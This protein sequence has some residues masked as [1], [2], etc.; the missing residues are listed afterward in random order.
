MERWLR[1]HR[2]GVASYLL[3]VLP[4]H[5]PLFE[6]TRQ[7]LLTYLR[8]QEGGTETRQSFLLS[9]PPSVLDLLANTT[10]QH[11]KVGSALFAFY[12]EV[13]EVLNQLGI[14]QNESPVGLGQ[15]WSYH[16][17]M[18]RSTPLRLVRLGRT[19]FRDRKW[20][21][22]EKE[23]SMVRQLVLP[24]QI[25]R[26]PWSR[27]KD[28]I[29]AV[30]EIAE[31]LQDTELWAQIEN[32]LLHHLFCWPLLVF[33]GSSGATANLGVSLPISV[34]LDLL[35]DD[36]SFEDASFDDTSFDRM[37]HRRY[38]TIN[39]QSGTISV[40]QWIDHLEQ[41]VR[42]GKKLWRAKHGNHGDFRK[43]VKRAKVIFDFTFAQA[44]VA[45][46]GRAGLGEISIVD[47]SAD[48]YFAQVVL[49][50]LRGGPG[51]LA[52]AVTGLIG[53]QLSH[54]D[55]T[56]ALNYKLIPPGRIA[57]KL[58]YV[59]YSGNF[60]R[61]VVPAGAEE[62]VQTMLMSSPSDTS[63]D[64]EAS[65]SMGVEFRQSA[66]TAEI[67]YAHDL[68][69]VADIV[70]VGGWRQYRYVRCPEVAWAVHSAR[71]RR[72]GLLD[73]KDSRV[74]QI[75]RFLSSN[76]SP[77]A[78][79]ANVS[80]IAVASALWHI[81]MT[82][83]PQILPYPPPSLSWVFIR[84]LDSEQ[85]SRF[86]QVLWR[87]VGASAEDFAKFL[88]H[89]STI[90]AVER[91]ANIFNKFEPD[92]E[93]PSHRAPDIIVL[94]GSE[95]FDNSANQTC[96]PLSRP[97]MVSPILKQ[98]NEHLL[99]PHDNRLLPLVG[100]TRILLL[101]ENKTESAA[102]HENV[103][104][105]SARDVSILRVL[106]TLRWGFSQQTASLLLSEFNLSGIAVRRLL[107]SLRNKG[108][109]RYGQG[110][111]HI[112]PSV[113]ATLQT[114]KDSNVLSRR[115]FAAGCALA[116]FVSRSTFPALTLDVA[117][118]AEHL[119]EA[120]MYF[121]LG[122]YY[123]HQS[124]NTKLLSLCRTALQ[125]LERFTVVPS[126]GTVDKLLKAQNLSRDA[127]ETAT[128][129]L[130]WQRSSNVTSHPSHLVSAARA[131]AQW[132]KS[133]RGP[134]DSNFQQMLR[135]QADGYFSQALQTCSEFPS[136]EGFNRLYVLTTYSA[137]LIENEPE[138]REELKRIARQAFE[139]LAG[140]ADGRAVWG[141]W[142][143][144]VADEEDEHSKASALYAIG[145]SWKPE[146]AQ[147]WVKGLGASSLGRLDES[148][149]EIRNSVSSDQAVSYLSRAEPGYRR[150]CKRGE[151]A[152]HISER[153]NEGLNRFEE[154]WG[155]NPNVR[156]ALERLRRHAR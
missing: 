16:A 51:I 143:E 135:K 104:P 142:F 76:G 81:N 109:L 71:Q 68:Q 50:K 144:W 29:A 140:G 98:L 47:G 122:I 114:D 127:Y 113:M 60:E 148:V 56:L 78:T 126:W 115:H 94:V 80:P 137:Y 25:L 103:E 31:L 49:N 18:S 146:W 17:L 145:R 106:A 121:S 15:I 89:P 85:D 10:R 84:P 7:L 2:I 129:L 5:D 3:H 12:P 39:G 65:D 36:Y 83:R 54:E 52:S 42:A 59:F 139:L 11:G 22:V 37:N 69:D 35:S 46:L 73:A 27:T 97:F 92:R 77:I 125:H 72:P 154:F 108:A 132:A 6:P 23:S 38:V 151:G 79:L 58:K 134:G 118:S 8:E 19:L 120:E 100:R 14:G 99:G 93:Y 117:F 119:H 102:D 141:E 20:R 62:E 61:V 124:S 149:E 105:L 33:L 70:Q 44:I 87:V 152:K 111:Y 32:I 41:S 123:A 40:D 67:Y 55:G 75:M 116:P 131:A 26:S 136:E 156:S 43:S 155:T 128:E 90:N 34:D 9:L 153:W 4:A 13:N 48:A 112:V 21:E 86:W 53:E 95:C 101:P 63:L 45:D 96:N 1:S 88:Q 28:K 150:H 82:L 130:S 107:Q 138:R 91:L 64:V 57:D 66:Q 24:L 133:F 147:L 30:R 74:Q 110:I